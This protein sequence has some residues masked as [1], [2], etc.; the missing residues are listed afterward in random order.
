MQAQL[1]FNLPDE[2]REFRIAQDAVAWMS[3]VHEL[4]NWLRGLS[5]HGDS[6][7]IKIEEVRARLHE[8]IAE[9][10]LQYD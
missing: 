10:N 1:I 9:R 7:T 2:D 8:E 5:K 6:D 3:V 4:D